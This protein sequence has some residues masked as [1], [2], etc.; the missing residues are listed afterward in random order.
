MQQVRACPDDARRPGLIRDP[1]LM[2]WSSLLRSTDQTA[3]EISA[4]YCSPRVPTAAVAF[5]AYPL[6][7]R[8]KDMVFLAADE[9]AGRAESV[10]DQPV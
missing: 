5:R 1:R 4:I 8:T 6:Y 10:V 2:I 3:I 9:S 7:K